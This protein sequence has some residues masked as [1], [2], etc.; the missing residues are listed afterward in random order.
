MTAYKDFVTDF[1]QRCVQLLDECQ[2]QIKTSG[3]EVTM[4]LALASSALIIPF[5]RLCPSSADHIAPDRNSERVSELGRLLNQSFVMWSGSKCWRELGSLSTRS[6]RGRHVEEWLDQ[7]AVIP[8]PIERRVGSVL[9][10][11]RNALAHGNLYSRE[12]CNGEIDALV[13]VSRRRDPHASTP[14]ANCGQRVR[15]LID[16]YEA[17]VST[18]ADFVSLLRIWVAVLVR[19]PL[20][21]DVVQETDFAADLPMVT[22]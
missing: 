17:L 14:C 20:Q 3:R 19:L 7:R 16:E 18:P 15:P 5:E 6:I 4:S 1:P 8:V 21:G 10:V 12:G 11:I 9:T 22:N 13:F 2:D